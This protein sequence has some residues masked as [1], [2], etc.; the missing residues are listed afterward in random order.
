MALIICRQR[1]RSTW[2]RPGRL[3]LLD[4]LPYKRSLEINQ[5][6]RKHKCYTDQCLCEGVRGCNRRNTNKEAFSF[7][8]LRPVLSICSQD[9][10][11]LCFNTFHPVLPVPV[12]LLPSPVELRSNSRCRFLS[13]Q[14]RGA[15]ASTVPGTR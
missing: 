14:Q 4:A 5:R 15:L 3:V 2:S 6:D 7:S 10:K 11:V 1:V 12:H 8:G 9:V 13:T